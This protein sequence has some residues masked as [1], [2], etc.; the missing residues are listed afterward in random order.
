MTRM[1]GPD[2]GAVS[3]EIAGREHRRH[4]DGTYHV[5]AIT[6]R[7]MRKTGDFVVV[8]TTISAPIGFRCQDCGFLAV[9]ADHCGRCDG[10]N[11]KPEHD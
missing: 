8:G 5:D 9:F 6:A 2:R 10:A 1:L 3:V 7:Q 4:K 11:L